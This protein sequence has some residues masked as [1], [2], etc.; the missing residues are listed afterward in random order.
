VVD[1]FVM[2]GSAAERMRMTD[3]R[4]VSG[5]W[6]ALV[7]QSFEPPGGPAEIHASKR[8]GIAGGGW[9]RRSCGRLHSTVNFTRF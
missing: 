6:S 5:F 1:D 4:C 2:Q 3:E 8:G 7:E 9:F